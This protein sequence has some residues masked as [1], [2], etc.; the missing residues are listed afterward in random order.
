VSRRTFSYVDHTFWR[1]VG[2]LKKRHPKLNSTPWY[3][4]NC[5]VG[6]SPRGRRRRTS[7]LALIVERRP[8]SSLSAPSTF[9]AAPAYLS[10]S[11]KVNW[12]VAGA[13][14][15]AGFQAGSRYR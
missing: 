15:G 2:W 12:P 10:R 5:P 11:T 1:I 7:G 3:A 9:Q 8:A 6:T 13:I 4:G 14:G